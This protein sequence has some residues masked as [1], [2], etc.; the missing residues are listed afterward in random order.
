MNFRPR[1]NLLLF[2]I[3]SYMHEY[4]NELMLNYFETG[5]FK[6]Y[7]PFFIDIHYKNELGKKSNDFIGLNYYS[8]FN[9]MVNLPMKF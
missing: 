8:H 5:E 9:I 3:A 2:S 4:F 7:I 6:A 1:S